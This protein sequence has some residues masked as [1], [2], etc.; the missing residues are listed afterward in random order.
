[1]RILHPRVPMRSRL[2]PL[3]VLLAGVALVLASCASST[4]Q[5]SGATPTTKPQ[6]TATTQPTTVHIYFTKMPDSSGNHKTFPVTRTVP[7]GADVKTFAIAQLIAGPTADERAAGYSSA[8]QGRMGTTGGASCGDAT[9]FALAMDARGPTREPGTLTVTLC[10][11]PT[12]QGNYLAWSQ[13]VDQLQA[14]MLH[15]PGVTAAVMLTAHDTC[16]DENGIGTR[17]LLPG[18]QT[19]VQVYFSKA[20]D[21]NSDAAKTFALTRSLPSGSDPAT[22]AIAQLITGPTA[23]EQS[24]GYFSALTGKLGVAG[25]L[26]CTSG[27]DFAVAMNMRGSRAETRTMTVTLCKSVTFQGNYL[28]WSQ[29][30]HTLQQTMLHLPGVQAAVILTSRGTCFDDQGD[31]TSCLR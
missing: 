2:F 13:S 20:P 21:S 28:Q 24:A 22:Y 26:N 11:G 30:V 8:L 1:M 27:S 17:C 9:D 16:Y 18:G 5:P 10:K 6:P 3:V 12:F 23:S 15:L 19:Q 4:A 31:S 14:T 29:S 25:G 7:Q